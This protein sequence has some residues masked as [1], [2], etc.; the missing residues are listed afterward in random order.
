MPHCFVG[1][2]VCIQRVV[3]VTVMCLGSAGHALLPILLLSYWNH[4]LLEQVWF[5]QQLSLNIQ[6]VVCETDRV[7]VVA[8]H[9]TWVV[10]E[11]QVY[12]GCYCTAWLTLAQQLSSIYVVS[13]LKLLS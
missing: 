10:L 13:K 1:S 9:C 4:C 5:V 7:T 12:E 11:V 3:M 2:E 6:C 8:L